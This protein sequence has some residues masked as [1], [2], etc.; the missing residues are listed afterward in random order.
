VSQIMTMNSLP[1]VLDP[2]LQKHDAPGVRAFVL[3]G[4]HARGE[5]GPHSDIDLVYF[6]DDSLPEAEAVTYLVDSQ[7]VV[8]SCVTPAKVE[9]WFS[10]P[11]AATSAIAGVRSARPLMDRQ[12][13]FAAIQ[14]RAKVFT[15]TEEMQAKADQ[16]AGNMMVGLIEEVH[17]GLEGLRRQDVGRLLNARF[18]LSW[19]LSKTMQVQRGILVSGDNGFYNEVAQAVGVQSRWTQ[20]RQQ[21]FGIE[22]STGRAPMLT[23]QVEAGLWLYVETAHLLGNSLSDRDAELVQQT[24]ERIRQTLGR[25]EPDA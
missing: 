3:M 5:A 11:D 2:L 9:S 7:L 4:S 23:E 25:A 19:L 6:V 18:G 21:A 15:W 8:V 12:G 20:L 22:G 13:Y 14:T 24:V 16:W 17:K 10:E 1:V